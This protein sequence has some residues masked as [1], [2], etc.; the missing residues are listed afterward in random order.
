M[1]IG[2]WIEPEE[3]PAGVVYGTILGGALLAAES[4]RHENL[5]EA[6]G[7]TALTLVLY[8]AAHTYA[9]ML[10]DRMESGQAWSPRQILGVAGREAALLKGAALPLIVLVVAA[11]IGAGT[12]D[13]VLAALVAAGLLLVVLEAIAGWRARLRGVELGLQVVVTAGLGVGIV[14]LKAV[15]H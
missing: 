2:G 7:A 13:A 3:N 8:W 6:V 12:A 4:T 11:L 10:G 5:A 15:L 1:R 14:L 9:R